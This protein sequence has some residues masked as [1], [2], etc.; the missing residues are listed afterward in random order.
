[1][2]SVAVTIVHFPVVIGVI[3][4]SRSRDMRPGDIAE[5]G[6]VSD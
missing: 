6:D 4:G 5:P 1:M 2:Q 3:A